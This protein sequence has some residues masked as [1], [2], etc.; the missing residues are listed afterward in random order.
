MASKSYVNELI[1][2]NYTIWSFTCKKAPNLKFLHSRFGA[3]VF[4]SFIVL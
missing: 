4:Y 1:I 2:I 3:F